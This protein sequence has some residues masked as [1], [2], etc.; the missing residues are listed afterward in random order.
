MRPVNAVIFTTL[1]IATQAHASGGIGPI[2]LNDSVIDISGADY[3]KTYPC[4]NR[5]VMIAGSKHVITLT[6]TCRSLD[7]SGAENMVT[8]TL[9]PGAKMTVSGS[10]QVVKWRSTRQPISDISGIEHQIDQVK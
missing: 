9:A 1:A 3:H 2:E 5:D 8:L 4:N 10:R 7:I 6:G